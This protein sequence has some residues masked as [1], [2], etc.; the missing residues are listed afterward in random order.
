MG[1]LQVVTEVLKR[2]RLHPLVQETVQSEQ[3]DR[4]QEVHHH[5]LSVQV[6]E[7]QEAAVRVHLS[8]QVQ[9][10]RGAAVQDHLS[11]QVR[12]ALRAVP[13]LLPV[14]H[15]LPHHHQ[16]AEG[17]NINPAKAGFFLIVL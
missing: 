3:S 14:H 1:H 4:G 9:E 16:E 2:V 5:L 17:N 12:E 11:D 15:H 13:V 10:V 8:D 7:V 6:Q